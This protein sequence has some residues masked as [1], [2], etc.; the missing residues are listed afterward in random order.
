MNKVQFFG[1]EVSK[2]IVGDNPF[3]GHS[4]I[5]DKTPGTEMR[6]WY[7]SSRILDTLFAIEDSGINTMLPLSD[8]FIVRLLGEYERAGGKMQWI[9]QPVGFVL[10]AVNL[11]NVMS[12]KNTIGI[13]HQ[14]TT[15]DFLF[16][17]GKTNEIVER[18]QRFKEGTGIP[19]GVG[20]HRPDVIETSEKDDWGADFYLACMYNARRN[21][22]GV[23][24]GFIT[25]KSKQGLQFRMDDRQI[26]LD[27]LKKVEK[28]VIAFKIFAGGQ[29]FLNRTPEEIRANIKDAY[30]TIFTALKPN[31][32]AAFGVFQRDKNELAEDV[33]VYE[34]WYRETQQGENA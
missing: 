6:E 20:T 16:E 12:L 31:D 17:T 10:E 13:Y 28:P 4:Y 14:G 25:G 7:T 2:L 21:R 11:R 19:V 33:E 24:S 32:F 27:T 26:M 9:W 3:N 8:P 30:N 15:T 29:M 18:I 1:K 22:E 23:E 5:T 34:E